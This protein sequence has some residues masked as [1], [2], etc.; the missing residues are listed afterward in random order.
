VSRIAAAKRHL[1]WEAFEAR[2]RSGLP[3][4]E[5]L[6]GSPPV[7]LI[8]EARG[9]RIGARLYSKERFRIPSP[10]AEVSICPVGVGDETALELTTGNQTLFQDFYALCCLIADRVQLE[11][12]PI[13]KA[14]GDTLAS[15]TA[16]ISKKRLL[17]ERSQ[18]GLIGEL[19]FL[20]RVAKE[21]GWKTAS[22]AWYGP[23][24][25]EHDFVLPKADAEVK[26]TTLERRVHEISSLTQLLPK[27]NRPLFLVSVQLTAGGE[28]RESFSLP[29]MVARVLTESA[30]VSRESADRI[31][32]QLD[33]LDWSDGDAV[34][35][36]NRFSLRSPFQASRVDE[37]FPAIVPATLAT[38]SRESAARFEKVSY[39]IN[40]DELGFPESSRDFAQLFYDGVGK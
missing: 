7:H 2:I 6:Q 5:P 26:T 32:Q 16:L 24:S 15:W 10:L 29:D 36:V 34:Y 8:I 38:I 40:V 12:Q 39:S 3:S 28:S 30:R 11:G 35:Y 13:S 19:L 31:R 18:V 14:V 37:T 9:R 33:D 17:D 27:P 23:E 1:T 22:A 21:L 4:V 20:R 25:E